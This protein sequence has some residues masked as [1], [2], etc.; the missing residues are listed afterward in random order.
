MSR[1]LLDTTVLI[2]FS[3]RRE[4][5]LSLVLRL[6]ADDEE[7]GACPIN[8]GEFYTGLAPA[9][10]HVWDEFLDALYFWPIS[11]AAARQ[12][13]IWRYDLARQGIALSMTDALIAAVAQAED[14]VLL[15]ANDRHFQE[16]DIRLVPVA[17]LPTDD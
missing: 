7:I 2:D 12:A 8:I 15:T 1:Y 5:A 16:L 17:N 9:D 3:K 4:P 10:R 11:P 6:I 13:G 14:A